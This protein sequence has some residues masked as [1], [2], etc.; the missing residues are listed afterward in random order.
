MPWGSWASP[1][2]GDEMPGDTNDCDHQGS[3]E[4]DGEAS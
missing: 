1:K 4:E 3:V 2:L